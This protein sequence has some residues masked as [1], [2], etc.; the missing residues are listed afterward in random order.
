M[1]NDVKA[2]KL[3][4]IYDELYKLYGDCECPLNHETPF[5]LLIA[6]ILSAQC[7]DKRVNMTTPELFSRFPDAESLSQA[8]LSEIEEIIK[9]IGLTKSKSKNIVETAKK[10]VADFGGEVPENMEDL[11]TLP[12]VGRKTANAV[13]PNAFGKPGSAVDSHVKR[14]LNR[15]GIVKSED[16]VKIEMVINKRVAPEKLGNFSHLLIWHGRNVC[17]ANKK[18][19][20]EKVC[21]LNNICAKRKK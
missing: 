21:V 4:I 3:A 17:H 8:D 14:L 10:I 7:T 6:V 2:K 5:Q 11:I 9:S 19:D 12:G 13:L 18:F 15:M 20:C 16:P 1:L